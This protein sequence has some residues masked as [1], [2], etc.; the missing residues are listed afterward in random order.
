MATKTLATWALALQFG[1][2]TEP[3][4]DMAVKSVYN[5]AGCAIGGYALPFAGIALDAMSPFTGSDGNST[6]FGIGQ[7]VDIR[8]AGLIK[9]R[10]FLA[11]LVELDP[12][13][14]NPCP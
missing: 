11:R 3:V 7:H 4:V 12:S 9:W 13:P 5:W 10:C 6:I 1:N 14:S 2:L 8:T